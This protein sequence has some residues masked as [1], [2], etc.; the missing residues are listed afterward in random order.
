MN[1][2]EYMNIRLK[3]IDSE[4]NNIFKSSSISLEN[5]FLDMLKYPLDAGGKRLR[6]ILTCLACELFNGDYKKAIIPA[7]S[8]ELIHTYSLVHDDLP[9]MDND[10]LRRGKP[11][12][13][14]K[15]GEANA[16][17][18]GD[19]LLTHSFEIL[20]NA[21]V[22]D[23]TL[24]KLLY[25]ISYAA[26]VSGMVMGQF[27]DLY[28]EERDI[29][30]EMLKILHSKKTGAMIRGAVRVGAIASEKENINLENIT[31]YG[32]AIGLAFQIQDDILDVISDN[33]TLGK[34]VGKDEKEGK[35]TY[36]KQFGL[37]GAK[38]KAI[39]TSKEAID[40]L[41]VYDDNEAKNI[42]IELAN[43]IVERKS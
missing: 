1:L 25:E 2:K 18:V 3:D 11:T 21:N 19:G 8:L 36:V 15:Y 38:E 42:L 35:L 34:T 7:V 17:L 24:R 12:T 5:N 10:D 14:V 9:A 32:E 6:P 16:I 40:Y 33:E 39:E 23:K 41:N 28:Y 43:Y 29:D 22:N 30:F 13:H 37:E 26:G 31:K 27:I 4:I 20:S